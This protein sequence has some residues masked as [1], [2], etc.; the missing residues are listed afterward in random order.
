MAVTAVLVDGALIPPEKV[1]AE[2]Q[3]VIAEV[4]TSRLVK[5]LV[6]VAPVAKGILSPGSVLA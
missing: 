1:G 4:G 2:E 5:D 3:I 6:H